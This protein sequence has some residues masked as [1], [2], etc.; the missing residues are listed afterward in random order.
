M[1]STPAQDFVARFAAD[2][3]AL[4]APDARVGVAVSGGPD[5]IALL[6]LAA[7][8]RPGLVEAA[9]V[10]H[11]LRPESRSEAETVA[12]VCKAI[13]V[14]HTVL[15]LEWPKA[16]DSNLQARAREA[17]F[18]VLGE[19]ALERRLAAVATAHHAD[20]QA[21]TLLMRLARGAGIG[22]LGSVRARRPL[23]KGVQLVRPLLR[24]RKAELVALVQKAGIKPVDD[25]SNRDARH[26]RVRMR[27][28]LKGADWADPERLAAS[29]AWLNEADE[30]LEWALAPIVE[31][32]LTGEGAALI[33][34]PSNI[35][36]ELQRRLL[37][38]AFAELGA[39]RPRGP[40]LSRALDALRKG[41]STT[42]SG[43]KLDGGAVWRLQPA[44]SRRG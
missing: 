30:A 20:D 34:D 15:T 38:A 32:R 19:W 2:L 33:I 4:A 43:L 39:P 37:L 35:P 26:D 6:L 40:E 13:A 1:N 8:A 7:A 10:D 31:T 14:P 41:G 28:W 25:P 5:S 27:Q 16:P 9:T 21:E 42:L 24:W 3:D 18:H 11:A 29:A 17:R 36:R 23:V 12:D 44:P 22:G